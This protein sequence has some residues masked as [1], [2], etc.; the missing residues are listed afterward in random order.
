MAGE[1]TTG[2]VLL[3]FW[4]SP[5]AQRCRIALAEKGLACESLEQELLG[6]KSDLLLGSNPVHKKV[7][8]LLHDGRAVCESLV[9]LEAFFGGE[10]LGFVDVALIPLTSWFYSYEKHGGFS[11]EEEC[12]GLAEWARRCG[13]RESV[14]KVLTPPEEVHDF[15]CLLKKHYGVE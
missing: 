2:L 8:V 11:V 3:D 12:P 15:I 5:F 7:P 13:E 6:A 9:I 1:K 4:V 14:A 10:A